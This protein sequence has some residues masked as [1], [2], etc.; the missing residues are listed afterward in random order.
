[1]RFVIDLVVVIFLV[2]YAECFLLVD[3]RSADTAANVVNTDGGSGIC[4]LKG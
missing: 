1:M 2:I 3:I 4:A